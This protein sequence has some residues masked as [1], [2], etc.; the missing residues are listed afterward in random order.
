MLMQSWSHVCHGLWSVTPVIL[1][2][3]KA[4]L[5]FKPEEIWRRCVMK[6]SITCPICGVAFISRDDPGPEA[7]LDLPHLWSKNRGGCSH[8]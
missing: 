6:I 8:S 2:N 4:I 3:D 1:I 5:G 7:V